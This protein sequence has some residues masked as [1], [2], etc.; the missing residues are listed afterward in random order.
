M[1]VPH[2]QCSFPFH[3]VW[4][5]EL[6][7]IFFFISCIILDKIFSSCFQLSSKW[8]TELLSD[9]YS[10]QLLSVLKYIICFCFQRSRK[11]PLKET[12]NDNLSPADQA[13]DKFQRSNESLIRSL[14]YGQQ[15]STVRC[16]KC[17]EESVTYEAFSDLSLPLPSSSNKCSLNVSF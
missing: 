15:K 17:S 1:L 14:F 13:W 9:L 4:Q 3:T 8:I 5:W 6:H 12:S 16:C 11:S 10:L 2:I 7:M